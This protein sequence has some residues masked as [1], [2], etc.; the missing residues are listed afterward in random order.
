L[1]IKR[2]D[3]LALD[4]AVSRDLTGWAVRAQIRAA[5]NDRL[6]AE[7]TVS[8]LPYDAEAGVTRYALT[9]APEVTRAWPMPVGTRPTYPAV[10][11]I[12]YTD[13]AGVVQSTETVALEIER[14]V[15]RPVV[16]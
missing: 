15:T 14:D 11:D 4:C 7:C 9:V 5:S 1:A 3:T 16:A 10:L 13:P 2:G 6:L 12:E 8:V